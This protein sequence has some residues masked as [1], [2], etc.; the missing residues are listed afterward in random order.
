MEIGEGNMTKIVEAIG[1]L[2]AAFLERIFKG[3]PKHK[4]AWTPEEIQ[5]EFS[6]AM[7]DVAICYFTTLEKEGRK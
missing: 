1:D 2:R 4:K 6:G 3:Y 7:Y 5:N